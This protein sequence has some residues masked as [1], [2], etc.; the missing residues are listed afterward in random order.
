MIVNV[1][2]IVIIINIY[3]T[4]ALANLIVIL[5]SNPSMYSEAIAKITM[6]YF[7]L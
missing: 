3:L 2:N 1:I 7:K 5:S 6:A 4:P